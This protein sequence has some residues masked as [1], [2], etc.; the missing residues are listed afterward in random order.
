MKKIK[1]ILT[2][3]ERAFLKT[4]KKSI[5]RGFKKVMQESGARN[6]LAGD[7]YKNWMTWRLI[8]M[9]EKVDQRSVCDINILQRWLK[10]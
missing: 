9:I 4:E 1:T 2:Q 10:K 6:Q 8:A 5:I 7:E 3:E